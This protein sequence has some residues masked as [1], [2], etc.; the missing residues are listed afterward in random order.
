MNNPP[1][2]GRPLREE[3]TL[4]DDLPSSVITDDSR[5]T[6]AAPAPPLPR[7]LP[8]WAWQ[9]HRM[10]HDPNNS[11]DAMFTNLATRDDTDLAAMFFARK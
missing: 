11:S 3:R 8:S 2:I 1:H 9:E 4:L 7:A 6:P 5:K 10:T